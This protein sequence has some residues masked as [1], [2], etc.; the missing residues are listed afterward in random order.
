MAVY[1][2]EL[3]PTTETLRLIEEGGGL[4]LV[5]AIKTSGQIRVVNLLFCPLSQ[6]SLLK[7]HRGYERSVRAGVLLAR[8]RS[9]T[10]SPSLFLQSG[11][12]HSV[13][14]SEN[15][16]EWSVCVFSPRAAASDSLLYVGYDADK[17]KLKYS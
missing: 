11:S 10:S 8:T 13:V 4:C 5:L 2:C 17:N 3:K 7:S 16:S 9:C 12:A 15:R 6:C 14:A 1:K